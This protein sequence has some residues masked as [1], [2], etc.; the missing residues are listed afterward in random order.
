MCS[1]SHAF[2]MNELSSGTVVARRLKRTSV[3]LGKMSPNCKESIKC[4][5]MKSSGNV[6]ASFHV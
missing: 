4:E 2:I 1:Y 5:I 6:N 3:I